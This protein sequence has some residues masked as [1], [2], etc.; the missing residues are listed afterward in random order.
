MA[1][2]MIVMKSQKLSMNSRVSDMLTITD[3]DGEE[4]SPSFYDRKKAMETGLKMAD[5]QL[6][7]SGELDERFMGKV[8][9]R[10]MS[11]GYDSSTCYY[12]IGALRKRSGERNE[13]EDVF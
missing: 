4:I 3:E 7:R 8:G 12:V 1:W 13:E 5:E 9:R 6:R 10:L 11:L 2:D